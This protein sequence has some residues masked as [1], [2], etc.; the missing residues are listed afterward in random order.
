M[1]KSK[2]LVLILHY[3]FAILN[4]ATIIK[5][6]NLVLVILSSEKSNISLHYL[7]GL[8]T[9]KKNVPILLTRLPLWLR[10]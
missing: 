5:T 9:S 1:L 3:I 8:G 7:Y 2:F 10:W 6:V 4:K